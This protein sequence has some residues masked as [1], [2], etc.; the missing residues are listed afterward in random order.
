VDHLPRELDAALMQRLEQVGGG[1][2]TVLG[3]QLAQVPPDHRH[4][5]PAPPHVLLP[6]PL[7]ALGAVDPPERGL[8][9][10]GLEVVGTEV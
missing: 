9:G 8:L 10:L 2:D 1:E 5:V 6:L 7:L 3:H 4:F